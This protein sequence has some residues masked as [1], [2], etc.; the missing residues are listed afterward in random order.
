MINLKRLVK[1]DFI[2]LVLSDEKIHL[3]E[4]ALLEFLYCVELT[5]TVDNDDP[6]MIGIFQS[7]QAPHKKVFHRILAFDHLIKACYTVPNDPTVP[8]LLVSF[9]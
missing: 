3:G 6:T 1:G 2:Q 5:V 7:S 9:C 8:T 4:I